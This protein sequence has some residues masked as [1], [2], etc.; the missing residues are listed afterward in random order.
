ML[1]DRDVVKAEAVSGN[2][3]SERIIQIAPKLEREVY[4]QLIINHNPVR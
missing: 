1:W 3:D 2:R 4:I